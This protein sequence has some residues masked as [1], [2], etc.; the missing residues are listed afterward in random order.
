M[1][2]KA[3]NPRGGASGADGN[4]GDDVVGKDTMGI[5]FSVPPL[6]PSIPPWPL[7]GVETGP[8]PCIHGFFFFLQIP[9]AILIIQ[10][11]VSPDKICWCSFHR[12]VKCRR[13]FSP[14]SSV[15]DCMRSVLSVALAV[16]ILPNGL[17]TSNNCLLQ[18]CTSALTNCLLN[19][20][21][22]STMWHSLTCRQTHTTAR[23]FTCSVRLRVWTV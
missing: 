17:N 13:I 15:Y 3:Q 21:N 6:S 7:S 20:Y 10:P 12:V 19:W 5:Y 18:L 14:L 9:Q 4:N 2:C 22:W 16:S 11:C 8:Y 1:M 23:S